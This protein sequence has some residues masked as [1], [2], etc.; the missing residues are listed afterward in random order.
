MWRKQVALNCIPYYLF[1]ARNTGAQHYFS[2]SLEKAWQIFRQSYQK[3]SG[4][5]RTVR[6]SVMSCLPGK[7]QVLGVAEILNRQAYVWRIIQGRNPDWIAKPF[8]A[9]YDQQ[10]IWYTNF[11]KPTFGERKFFFMSELDAM[12][13]NNIESEAEDLE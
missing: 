5:C 13:G 12:L 4:I 8:L 1:I 11:L 2:V 9:E 3:V 7:V 6:G 10:A